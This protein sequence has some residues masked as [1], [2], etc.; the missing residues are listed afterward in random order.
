MNYPHL[1]SPIELGGLTLRNRVVMGSMH[2][3][4]ED[5][6]RDLPALA[7]YFAERA[8]GGVGL[9]VTGGYAPNKRGWLKPFAS[10]MTTRLHAM[11]HRE[12]TGAVHDEGGAIALQV[13]HAGRYG[14]HPLS[15]SASRQRSPITPFRPSALSTRAVDRTATDFARSVALARKAGYD[16]VEIM[17]SEGYLVNQFLA[18]RTNDRTDAWGGTAEKRMRFPLEVVRRSRELVGDDFPIVYRIS[19]LDLV[20][21]GQTWEEVVDLAHGLEEAGVT[22]LNT[23]IGWHEARVP[24]IITQV[25]QGA[26]RWATARLKAEVSVPVCASN[27]INSPETAESILAAGEADLVSMARPLLA[28][29]DF[30]A[31]AAAGRADEINTCIAC[32]QAC[33]DHVFQNRKASCLVNPRACRETTLVLAP[34]EL[35][36][37][38]RARSVAVVGAGPAGLA[39]AVSAAERGF[40]VT[41]F[42][43]APELGGQFRLAM[44]VPG[45]EDF[46][47][48]LRYYTRRLEV[49][50]VDVRLDTEATAPDLA[51]YDEVVVATGVVGR[52][53]Q[54]DGIDHAKVASYAEVLSGAVVP[55]RRVAVIGAG[56]IGVDVSHFLTHD[57]A[58]GLDDWMAHWGVGDPG[59][60]PGGLTERKPRTPVRDVTL[61]QRKTTPIGI[62]LGKTSGWAHRAVL[63]QSGVVQVSGVTYDR[64]DDAGLHYTVDGESQVLDVDHVVLCAGQESVR[65]LYDDLVA[66]GSN[67]HLVGGADVAAELDAKRAIEQ[68]TRVA[69]GL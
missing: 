47:E 48:T 69:A 21:G 26:W 8:R 65:H 58:D 6:V 52:T 20:E 63:K 14:Y 53:P 43:K 4:L 41:L 7:A 1:L 42:E 57:P 61:L 45:K 9:I 59:V 66:A 19:L 5:R 67:V 31:K 54:L 64:V 51:A 55:G 44:Q 23:G 68:G 12:V 3:G 27:R 39:A 15:V 56:G 62:G 22:V 25:P 35:G 18:A 29:P 37:T 10:E 33:L 13:L 11:R 30:V 49:L 34:L 2:T 38:R 46:R 32:N 24:T 28:D 17:G 60:H 16:A 50:G 36:P 40:A